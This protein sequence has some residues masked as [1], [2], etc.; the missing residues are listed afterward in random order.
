MGKNL[1][2]GSTNYDDGTDVQ[3]WSLFGSLSSLVNVYYHINKI[4]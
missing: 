4:V 2:Q 1:L 3:D